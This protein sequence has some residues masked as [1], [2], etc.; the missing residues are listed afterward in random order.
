MKTFKGVRIGQELTVTLTPDR[1][2][3]VPRAVLC[4]VEL[5]AEERE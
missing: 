5:V 2:A 4:G 1:T 3:A